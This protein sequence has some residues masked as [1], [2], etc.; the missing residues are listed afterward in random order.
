MV[1]G[2]ARSTFQKTTILKEKNQMQNEKVVTKNMFFGFL[3]FA[4]L[5]SIL[6]LG[7]EASAQ[8]ACNPSSSNYATCV[9]WHYQLNQGQRDSLIDSQGYTDALNRIYGGDC[10]SYARNLVLKV[11]RNIVNLPS[12]SSDSSW[13]PDPNV[14]QVSEPWWGLYNGQIVQMRI[15]FADGHYGHHTA[16]VDGHDLYGVW[17]IDSNFCSANTVCRHYLTYDYLR[18]KVT[19]Y[20]VYDIK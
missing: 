3:G 14:T 16:V 13:Y 4:V 1:N 15:Q 18:A 2:D 9:W 10:K 6:L 8:A 19:A 12:N 20:S 7:R 17:F 11:S 5:F